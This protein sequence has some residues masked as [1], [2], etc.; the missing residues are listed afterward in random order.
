M[1]ENKKVLLFTE[2]VAK[3]TASSDGGSEA[4]FVRSRQ[5]FTKFAKLGA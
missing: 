5:K 3:K 2:I 1:K 4:Q